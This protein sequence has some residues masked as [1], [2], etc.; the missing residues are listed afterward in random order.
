MRQ[1]AAASTTSAAAGGAM[2]DFRKGVPYADMTIG[3]P[4]EI[5]PSECRVAG[6]PETVKKLAAQGFR[7]RVEHGAGERA[8]FSD[9]MVRGGGGGGRGGVVA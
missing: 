5:F 4:R 2:G 8:G 7:V 9:E 1:T 6:T 3:I